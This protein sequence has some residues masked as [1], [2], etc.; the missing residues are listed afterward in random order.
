LNNQSLSFNGHAKPNPKM[1]YAHWVISLLRRC[2]SNVAGWERDQEKFPTK[3]WPSV[4]GTWLR[5]A[6]LLALAVELGDQVPENVLV[7]DPLQGFIGS[8]KT[9]LD[10]SAPEEADIATSMHEGW[11]L[12]KAE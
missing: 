1:L 4:A 7:Q 3:I 5:K 8:S 10:K 12:R 11:T 2:N 6:T 9:G